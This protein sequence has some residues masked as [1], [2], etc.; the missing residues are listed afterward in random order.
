MVSKYLERNVPILGGRGKY[1]VDARFMR[2]VALLVLLAVSFSVYANSLEGGFVFED[3]SF[4]HQDNFIK[5]PHYIPQIF[6]GAHYPVFLSHNLYRPLRSLSYM[7]DYQLWGYRAF[8]YKLTNLLLHCLNVLLV[9]LLAT[10]LLE[11]RCAAF[12][13]ALF[14]AVH[15]VHTEVVNAIYNRSDSLYVFFYLLSLLFFIGYLTYSRPS[16]S[17]GWPRPV[18]FYS[19]SLLAFLGSLCSKES[20]ITALPMLILL[21]HAFK[22][23]WCRQKYVD[24]PKGY[25]C[26]LQFWI[27]GVT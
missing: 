7:L 15:P 1:K 21:H 11:T 16:A 27:I 24:I 13:T 5:Q 20:A 22:R 14:F 26:H 3:Y 10:Y 23:G 6:G 18:V 2:T 19:L 25:L 8:G 4:I 17:G 9:Y 12:L